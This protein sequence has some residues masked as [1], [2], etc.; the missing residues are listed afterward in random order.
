MVL[1]KHPHVWLLSD[2]IYEHISYTDFAS[3]A[4]VLPNLSNRLLV[5]NGVSKAHSMTGW[6]IGWGIGPCDLIKA[7]T[8]VQGQVTSG[9]SSISQAAAMDAPLVSSDYVE[10]RKNEF[11]RRRNMIQTKLEDIEGI[12][13]SQPD[14]AFYLFPSGQTLLC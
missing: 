10:T 8:A 7:M 5:V 2:E 6:R 9:A 12:S 1:A 13:C 14:G 4:D 11:E 3:C